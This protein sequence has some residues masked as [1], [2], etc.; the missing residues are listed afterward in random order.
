MVHSLLCHLLNDLPN[1]PSIMFTQ[2]V[3]ATA[4]I[5]HCHLYLVYFWAFHPVWSIFHL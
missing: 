4:I 2:I 3:A 1:S 5:S